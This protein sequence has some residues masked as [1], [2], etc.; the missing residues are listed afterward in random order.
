MS[1]CRSSSLTAASGASSVGAIA[2]LAV[3]ALGAVAA[4]R[5]VKQ[6][7]E[8]VLEAAGLDRAVHPAF[9]RRA[10]LPPPSAGARILPLADRARARLASDRL[11]ALVVERVV[12]TVVGP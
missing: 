6:R 5:L 7:R 12:G 10:R 1:R 3:A 9:F 8:L 4:L 11:V 2:R